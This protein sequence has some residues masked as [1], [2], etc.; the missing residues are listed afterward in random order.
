M[1]MDQKLFEDADLKMM[2]RC[3]ELSRLGTLEGEFPFAAVISKNGEIVAEEANRVVRDNDITRHAE[4]LAISR[5]QESLGKGKLGGCTL[6]SNIEPCAMCSFP[7]RE[8]RIS[9]V[10]FAISSP[11]MGGF[12]KWGILGDSELSTVMPEAFSKPPEVVA[13]VMRQEAEQVWRKWNPLIWGIIRYRGCFGPDHHH[14]PGD[15]S[16]ARRGDPEARPQRGLLRNL[17]TPHR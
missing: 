6:Y 11:L 16:S 15:S 4:L 12:S 3:I 1:A 7:I 13:G 17:L 8:S 14:A 2:G 10:V 9:R 5:A